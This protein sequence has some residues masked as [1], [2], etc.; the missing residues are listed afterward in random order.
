[1]F[2]QES[3]LYYGVYLHLITAKTRGL[4]KM[5]EIHYEEI[6]QLVDKKLEKPMQ[7]MKK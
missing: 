7:I 3:V 5:T 4:W 6:K 2:M 1:M